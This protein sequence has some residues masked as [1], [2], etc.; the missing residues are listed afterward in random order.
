MLRLLI[1][2]LV[3]HDHAKIVAV[4]VI[5]AFHAVVCSRGW[6]SVVGIGVVVVVVVMVVVVVVVVW[7]WWLWGVVVVIVLVQAVRH[8]ARHR[9]SQL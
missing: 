9:V 3:D 8:S 6:T 1:L 4:V 5:A 7:S 2:D